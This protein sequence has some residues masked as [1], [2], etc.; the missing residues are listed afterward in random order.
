MQSLLKKRGLVSNHLTNLDVH[1]RE[2]WATQNSVNDYFKITEIVQPPWLVKV[3]TFIAP[4]NSLKIFG[5]QEIIIK[6]ITFKKI[7]HTEFS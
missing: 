2:T 5:S 3:L 4:I 1:A 6:S 7:N